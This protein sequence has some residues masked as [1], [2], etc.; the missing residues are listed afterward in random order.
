MDD[1]WDNHGI[2]Q[3]EQYEPKKSVDQAHSSCAEDVF[4]YCNEVQQSMLAMH[5]THQDQLSKYSQTWGG[6]RPMELN[7]IDETGSLSAA[8]KTIIS[9]PAEIALSEKHD[10]LELPK[11][12][13]GMVGCNKKGERHNTDKK[14]G[15]ADN[16]KILLTTS[17]QIGAPPSAFNPSSPAARFSSNV[18]EEKFNELDDNGS[19]NSNKLQLLS[20]IKKKQKTRDTICK[21]PK[22]DAH[23]IS[24]EEPC[25]LRK[26]NNKNNLSIS[27]DGKHVTVTGLGIQNDSK[28]DSKNV[29]DGPW[30][31]VYEDLWMATTPKDGY[32]EENKQHP[33]DITNEPEFLSTKNNLSVLVCN[34]DYSVPNELER[35]N[36]IDKMEPLIQPN[37][38]P[39][40]DNQQPNAQNLPFA[41][42]ELKSSIKQ[43]RKSIDSRKSVRFADFCKDDVDDIKTH[44]SNAAA[45]ISPSSISARFELDSASLLDIPE[46]DTQFSDYVSEIAD[47]KEDSFD[48]QENPMDFDRCFEE[49]DRVNKVGGIKVD[50]KYLELSDHNCKTGSTA[51]TEETFNSTATTAEQMA[52]LLH[53]NRDSLCFSGPL[54]VEDFA[55]TS[56]KDNTDDLHFSS[57]LIME[58]A[59]TEVK[60]NTNYLCFSGPLIREHFEQAEVK[61]FVQTDAEDF[62]RMEEEDAGQIEDENKI[63]LDSLFKLIKD[64]ISKFAANIIRKK[65]ENP[66]LRAIEEPKL[67]RENTSLTFLFG[68]TMEGLA[69]DYCAPV[70]E[71]KKLYFGEEEFAVTKLVKTAW[72]KKKSATT[73]Y[74]RQFLNYFWAV[75]TFSD[76]RD[77][78]SI[79]ALTEKEAAF[80][81]MAVFLYYSHGQLNN[82]LSLIIFE[83]T[84]HLAT[85]EVFGKLSG[86]RAQKF[87]IKHTKSNCPETKS[88]YSSVT[89]KSYH[90]VKSWRRFT[91]MSGFSPGL[92]CFKWLCRIV[93]D[94]KIGPINNARDR[95]IEYHIKLREEEFD[96]EKKCIVDDIR[97]GYFDQPTT[98]AFPAPDN[99]DRPTNSFSSRNIKRRSNN[100]DLIGS[101]QKKTKRSSNVDGSEA[102]RPSI[103]SEQPQNMDPVKIKVSVKT[104]TGVIFIRNCHI[105]MSQKPKKD[106]PKT[107]TFAKL[108]AEIEKFNLEH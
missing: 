85:S 87:I 86:M 29:T 56:V 7:E 4:K 79:E 68:D 1:L 97:R 69:K 30:V 91:D 71:F 21:I 40:Q 51:E 38:F 42:L 14:E 19:V 63:D 66:K 24:D 76:M 41:R 28:L 36:F 92:K 72:K 43:N 15:E 23:Q 98:C 3:Q 99:V 75:T 35:H 84:L 82:D 26:A 62:E 106:P 67:L 61:E 13:L 50:E 64:D 94:E 80:F 2:H 9:S 93:T 31:S 103:S 46:L 70:V 20:Q 58:H 78:K 25:V 77:V 107:P 60:D 47:E 105:A 89:R 100:E 22:I 5:Y 8:T 108:N 88:P 59:Q 74:Y 39:I 73:M 102:T 32:M 18:M 27:S 45:A 101:T 10:I 33:L 83:L 57:P 17:F 6:L 65:L 104:D 54:I 95:L 11:H 44:D 81:Y 12:M 16:S 52:P 55:Q 48:G 34:L 49:I 37:L 90:A 96:T 53:C